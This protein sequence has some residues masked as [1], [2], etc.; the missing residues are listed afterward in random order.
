M[1]VLGP[2]WNRA[3]HILQHGPAMVRAAVDDA[4]RLVAE[5]ALEQARDNLRGGRGMAPLR[6]LTLLARRLA[7]VRG[8]KPLNA[9]GELEEA[10]E[11]RRRGYANYWVGVAGPRARI[12]AIQEEGAGPFVVRVTPRMRAFLFGRLL[13]GESDGGGGT[14][15]SGKGYIVVKIPPR[16]FLAPALARVSSPSRVAF[17]FARALAVRARGAFGRP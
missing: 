4:A 3:R 9:S 12:A 2:G 7:G 11:L 6:P 17:V 13:R 10:L 16:P 5:D 8:K 1:I 15:S 14:N